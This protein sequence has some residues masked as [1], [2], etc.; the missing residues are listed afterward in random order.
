M[1]EW[2]LLAYPVALI[3]CLMLAARWQPKDSPAPVEDR[4]PGVRRH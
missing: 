1:S 3:A 2:L 4:R